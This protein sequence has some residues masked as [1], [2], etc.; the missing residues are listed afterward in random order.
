MKIWC[1]L[2][3]ILHLL[4]FQSS[5]GAAWV[6][7]KD[8]SQLFLEAGVLNFKKYGQIKGEKKVTQVHQKIYSKVNY[9]RGIEENLTFGIKLD[10]MKLAG[11]KE[12]LYNKLEQK[13]E[14][15]SAKKK[16]RIDY[17]EV[18]FRK[19][20]WKKDSMVFSVQPSFQYGRHDGYY[21]VRGLVGKSFELRGLYHFIG[22]EFAY[23]NSLSGKNANYKIDL[24]FGYRFDEE[25][26]YISQLFGTIHK[27]Y[28]GVRHKNVDF[29]ISMV[30]TLSDK[31]DLQVGSRFNVINRRNY[32]NGC[33]FVSLWIKL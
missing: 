18:Y 32:R 2:V 33:G 4:V 5:Q 10:Y 11:Y 30:K 9:E 20:L 25:S 17:V 8:K 19:E 26:M 1:W 15:V 16:A 22:A 31:I 13:Y 12:L 21:E 28:Y 27:D 23:I 29:Q 24:S 14:L 7:E 6:L 3:S